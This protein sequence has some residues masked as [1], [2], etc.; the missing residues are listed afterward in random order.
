MTKFK[1]TLK[2]QQAVLCLMVQILISAEEKKRLEVLF[3][4]LDSN[5][6]GVV[7]Y[8]ELVQG[9]IQL[10]G[11]RVGQEECKRVFLAIDT[12][13][14]GEIEL[15]EFLQACVD[16]EQ[17]LHES[18]LRQSFAFFDKDNSGSIT[19]EE[20]KGALGAE[21]NITDEVWAQ[22]ILEV[23]DNGDGQIDFEEFTDMMMK[24]V[25]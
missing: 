22:V 21:K 18:S 7:T 14:S 4:Q 19:P 2:L 24:L 23:D 5:G 9:F 15:Q 25:C 10:Y 12:D 3:R 1:I 13:G 6:D 16:K 11:E 8:D 17:L 20:L